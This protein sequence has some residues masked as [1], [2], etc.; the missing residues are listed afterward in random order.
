VLL[1]A[2]T[3]PCNDP[4]SKVSSGGCCRRCLDCDLDCKH[5][6][7]R[8]DLDLLHWV[9]GGGMHLCVL[10]V[11]CWLTQCRPATQ[12]L[13]N[14]SSALNQLDASPGYSPGSAGVC[15]CCRGGNKHNCVNDALV[16]LAFWCCLSSDPQTAGT[17]DK[18]L[19]KL[20]LVHGSMCVASSSCRCA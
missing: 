5:L 8:P 3:S 14:I 12:G 1:T 15:A 20:R 13:H 2:V 6:P 19:G 10:L 9:S 18:C 7:K 4:T 11:C 17:G 16:V